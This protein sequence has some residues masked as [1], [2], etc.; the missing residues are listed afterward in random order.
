MI[1]FNKYKETTK[2]K[3]VKPKIDAKKRDIQ[4]AAPQYGS[5]TQ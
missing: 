3:A 2:Y 4:S 1:D 5:N